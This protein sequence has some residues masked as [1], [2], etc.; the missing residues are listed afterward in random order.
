MNRLHRHGWVVLTA[1]LG[2]VSACAVTGGSVEADYGGGYYQPYGYY[3]PYGYE[4]GGWGTG[5][6]VGPR[7]GG[8]HHDGDHHE[9]DHHGGDHHDGDRGNHGPGAGRGAGSAPGRP[10]RPAPPTR[11]MPSIPG[12]PRGH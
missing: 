11:S 2:F 1:A 9:G 12:H 8:G 5:Y 7:W 10:Y 4:Y 6:R 3:E